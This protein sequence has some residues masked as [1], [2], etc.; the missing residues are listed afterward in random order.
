M[1]IVIFC[2][3]SQTRPANF[4]NEVQIF[5]ADPNRPKMLARLTPPFRDSAYLSVFV[6]YNPIFKY[7]TEQW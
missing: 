7:A 3:L 6:G 4:T 1:A 5:T 2:H